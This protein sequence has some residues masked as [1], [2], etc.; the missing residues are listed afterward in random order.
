VIENT[1]S[2]K[3]YSVSVFSQ[4]TSHFFFIS[5][6]CTLLKSVALPKRALISFILFYFTLSVASLPLQ[7]AFF[8]DLSKFL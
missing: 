4:E 6:F 8:E 1:I 3:Y 2:K 5:L 7:I